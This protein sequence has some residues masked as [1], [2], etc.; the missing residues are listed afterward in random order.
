MMFA[1]RTWWVDAVGTTLL[2]L[3]VDP[4][5]LVDRRGRRR[6]WRPLLAIVWTIRTLSRS[7]PRA[8]LAGAGA[9]PVGR[10]R[11]RERRWLAPAA[12]IVAAL[13]VRAV[14]RERDSRRR[15]I[16]R[17]RRA[18]AG[19]RPRG[20]PRLDRGH[21]R[22]AANGPAPRIG[23]VTALG[24]R[25]ASWRPGRSLTVAGLVAA[26]VFLLVSVDSFRK[27]AGATGATRFRH[28][29]IRADR[30]IRDSDRA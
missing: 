8:Q 3:H 17:R 6:R 5:S 18:R 10:A 25:N 1:L 9:E 19:R 22:R 14:A 23:S 12:L 21:V 24:V 13:L 16:L 7:T 2:R 27:T 26:A 29:R 28:R 30:G 11:A 20:V 15:R 4:S